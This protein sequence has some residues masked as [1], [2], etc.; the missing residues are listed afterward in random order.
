MAHVWPLYD[1]VLRTPRLELRP[2][3]EP[4]MFDLT[5]LAG[6]GIHAPATMP[7]LTPFTDLPTVERERSSLRFHWGNWANWS[8]DDWTLSFVVRRDGECVGAQDLCGVRYP[9]RRTVSSGSWLGRANQGRGLGTEMRAAVLELAFGALE[10]LRA[11]SE[12]F[13][14]SVASRRVSDKLGYRS[15]GWSWERARDRRV[16][17]DR[18][19]L[20]VEDWNCPVAVSVEGVS[21]ELLDLFGI[22]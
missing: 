4:D 21:P 13:A 10:A 1:L 14:D 15:N 3:R 12:A 2:V 7:F 17:A 22:D 18:F 11:E 20:D 16:R 9:V 8:A 5:E 6:R 19:A